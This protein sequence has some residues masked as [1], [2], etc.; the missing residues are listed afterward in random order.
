MIK[1]FDFKQFSL[2]EVILLELSKM[3]NSSIRSIERTISGS[4]TLNQGG[5]GSKCN[6]CVLHIPQSSKTGALPSDSLMSYTGH[7]LGESY[8][9]AEIQSVFSTAPADKGLRRSSISRDI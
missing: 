8:R 7:S 1:L 9:S 5:P 2:A 3:S 4:T 6:E